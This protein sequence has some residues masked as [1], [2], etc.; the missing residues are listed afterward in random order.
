MLGPAVMKLRLSHFPKWLQCVATSIVAVI[1]LGVVVLLIYELVAVLQK[2]PDDLFGRVRAIL[3]TTAAVIGLPFLIWRTRI[4]D[5]QNQIN[6]EGHSTELFSKAVELLSTTRTGEDGRDI[7][8]TEARVGAI[9][10]LERLSK[11]SAPDHG[12]IVETLSAYV[13]ERCGKGSSFAFAGDDP[14]EEGIPIEEK[15]RRLREWAK[16][17]HEWIAD[18]RRDPPANRADTT[19]AL[20]VL[21]RR[22]QG[23]QWTMAKAEEEVLPN[24]RGANLQGADVSETMEGLFEGL[25]HRDLSGTRV[26]AAILDGLHIENSP[27]LGLSMVHELTGTRVVPSSLTGV[28]AWHLTVKS[29]ELLPYLDGADLSF[30]NMDD[31]NCKKSRFRAA[32]L[33]RANFRNAI[34]T[35]AKF[36]VANASYAVFDGADLTEVE[37]LNALLEGASFVGAN[38]TGTMLQYA[39]LYGAKLDGALLAGT[40]FTDARYLEPEMVERGFGTID[41]I[42]PAGMARPSHWTDMPSAIEKWRAYRTRMGIPTVK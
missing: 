16:A 18:L 17:L 41:T 1:L 38:L 29:A 19:V 13:R 6:R 26:E 25:T 42:L 34:L 33:V 21:S 5:R 22:K 36:G 15:S 39:I 3:L 9:F 40:D 2:Q 8:A 12:P 31:A 28:H 32:R 30:A 24:L 20:T 27:L 7:P 37:L 35:Q 10:A 23:R 4:A 14:D 11:T